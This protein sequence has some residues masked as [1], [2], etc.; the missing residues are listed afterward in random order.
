MGVSHW[1]KVAE[2]VPAEE[3]KFGVGFF[4]C[5]ARC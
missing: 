4:S 2:M 1:E 3:F 5:G